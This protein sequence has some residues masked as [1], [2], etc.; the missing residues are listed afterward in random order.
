MSAAASGPCASW[1]AQAVAR[2]LAPREASGWSSAAA[3]LRRGAMSW[4]VV[5]AASW[6]EGGATP[7]CPAVSDECVEK[8][9]TPA[10]HE[11][12][13]FAL[14]FCVPSL[15]ERAGS[16]PVGTTVDA[17]ASKSPFH[18]GWRVGQRRAG[19][20]GGWVLARVAAVPAFGRKFTCARGLARAATHGRLASTACKRRLNF[21]AATR[22]SASERPEELT[23]VNNRCASRE[24]ITAKQIR[25]G[26]AP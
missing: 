10:A 8:A 25:C 23:R 12:V 22:P 14:P 6:L 24:F 18:T 9:A 1:R 20:C 5:R 16:M 3:G 2:H 4:C 11:Y 21:S 15:L 17:R 26:A 19:R 7:G 13:S